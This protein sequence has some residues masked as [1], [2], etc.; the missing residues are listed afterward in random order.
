MYQTVCNVFYRC[1]HLIFTPHL[2]GWYFHLLFYHWETFFTRWVKWLHQHSKWAKHIPLPK[3]HD[4]YNL[5][6]EIK[7]KCSGDEK[8]GDITALD[9]GRDD[10]MRWRWVGSVWLV[11][12]VCLIPRRLCSSSAGEWPFWLLSFCAYMH[13]VQS[14]C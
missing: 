11:K 8:E 3:C 1:C 5:I 2:R 4:V 7:L 14:I 10:L 12:P 6:Q 13:E 9:S